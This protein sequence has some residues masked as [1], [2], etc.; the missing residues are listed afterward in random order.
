MF[1]EICQLI[2]DLTGFAIGTK[3]QIGHLK[4]NAPVRYVLIQETGG[5]PEFFPN[6]DMA[7]VAIQILNRAATYFEARED[8]HAVYTAIH[9]TSGWTLP[10]MDG[11]GED[12]LAMT[13]EAVYLPQ[14]LGVDENNRHIF[15]TNYI[16]RM[17]LG[18]CGGPSW[19]PE[20][21]TNGSFETGVG[22][23]SAFPGG[24]CSFA[25]VAGGVDGG[26][27]LE[28]TRL[29]GAAQTVMATVSGLV[30]GRSYELSGWVKSGSSGNESAVLG[31]Y[32]SPTW[33][34]GRQVITITSG[35]WRRLKMSFVAMAADYFITMGKMSATPGTMLFDEMS[36]TE[37]PS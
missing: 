16:F 25:S 35:E 1:R 32:V 27:C 12:C 24:I 18:A 23:W 37:F 22:G 26:N 19:T 4:Q 17:E 3:L 20:L 28:M 7:D 21:L 36:L 8:A 9:G 5:P 29:G 15:S 11:S 14:Y 6:E 13:V 2:A 34:N 30:V 31:A 33:A 10:R